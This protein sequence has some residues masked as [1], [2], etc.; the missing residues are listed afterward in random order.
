LVGFNVASPK[1]PA[2]S[3]LAYAMSGVDG[4]LPDTYGLSA[5][6]LASVMI[7]WR[8]RVAVAPLRSF[9]LDP[10]QNERKIAP[11]SGVIF[12]REARLDR[13]LF[14]YVIVGL[15]VA[16]FI[17][18]SVAM[19]WQNQFFSSLDTVI[20]VFIALV[21]G[22][23]F[24]DIGWPRWLGIVLVLVIMLAVPIVL[25]TVAGRPNVPGLGFALLLVL[26]L[27][28]GTRPSR[29]THFALQNKPDQPI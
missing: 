15:L 25:M 9:D 12:G 18:A 28:A 13:R 22:A 27:V 21:V 7:Q 23:R 11:V 6:E 24:G 26:I 4:T 16:K 1:K 5:D 10:Q 8:E 20:V 3:K 17:V 2:L 14:W 29:S 19:N